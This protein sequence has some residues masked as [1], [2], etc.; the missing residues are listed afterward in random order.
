[1]TASE[2]KALVEANGNEPHFFTRGTMKFFGD[3]MRNYA[4]S[5]PVEIKTY[6]GETVAVWELRRIQPVKHGLM[7]SAYFDCETYQR[8]FPVLNQDQRAEAAS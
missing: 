8:R 5:G 6:T 3:T 1:M 4:V 7:A 2:L